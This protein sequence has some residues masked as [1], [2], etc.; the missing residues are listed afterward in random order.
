[1]KYIV[2]IFVISQ[3]LVSR[4]FALQTT[5]TRATRDRRGFPAESAH[6]V[7]RRS[8]ASGGRGT[9]Q[10]GTDEAVTSLH[11]FRG[12][13][14]VNNLSRSS[15]TTPNGVTNLPCRPLGREAAGTWPR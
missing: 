10:C 7:V 12:V 5:A 9:K 8:L 15:P 6:A 1:M 14:R 2:T 3:F 4:L 13:W 11:Q